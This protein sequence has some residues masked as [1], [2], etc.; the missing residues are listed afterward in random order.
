MENKETIIS[1][2]PPDEAGN[3]QKRAEIRFDCLVKMYDVGYITSKGSVLSFTPPK[4]HAPQWFKSVSYLTLEKIKY[5]DP[6]VI[7][8]QIKQQ[9]EGLERAIKQYEDSHD[10]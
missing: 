2:V 7:G 3:N 6:Y 4:P 10:R 8:V 9:F 1:P 5:E